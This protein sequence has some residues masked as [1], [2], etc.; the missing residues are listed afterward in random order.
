MLISAAPLDK[1]GSV[2]TTLAVVKVYELVLRGGHK[3]AMNV[4]LRQLI[5]HLQ[6][7]NE[8][9]MHRSI[10]SVAYGNLA[11]LMYRKPNQVSLSLCH[12]PKQYEIVVATNVIT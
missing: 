10:S 9:Q 11:Y 4:L 2:F 8:L 1:S 3:V 7:K 5:I 12:E 6:Y